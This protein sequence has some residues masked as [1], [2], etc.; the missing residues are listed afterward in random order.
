MARRSMTV[1]DSSPCYFPLYT[2]S[3]IKKPYNL[4]NVSVSKR[5]TEKICGTLRICDYRI[6]E[7]SAC[8]YLYLLSA[9]VVTNLSC[10]YLYLL[11]AE[12]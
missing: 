2:H 7:K 1:E 11:S 4:D 10:M 8:M 9:D 6:S 5:T 3:A 12:H